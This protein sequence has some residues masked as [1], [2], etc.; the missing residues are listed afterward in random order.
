MMLWSLLTY[1]NQKQQLNKTRPT[2]LL[3]FDSTYSNQKQ[4]LNKT[5]LMKQ[6]GLC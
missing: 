5:K 4:Q 6:A 1:S 2:F 3:S